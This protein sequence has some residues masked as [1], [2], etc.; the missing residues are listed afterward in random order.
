MGG[1]VWE[2]LR[3]QGVLFGPQVEPSTFVF[4]F[5]RA[6]QARRNQ[7]PVFAS[8]RCEATPFS[9]LVFALVPAVPQ[10]NS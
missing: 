3:T 1:K 6:A 7:L 8:G 5:D 9:L 4:V 10:V 2:S